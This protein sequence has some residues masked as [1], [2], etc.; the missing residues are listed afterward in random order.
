[1]KIHV[2]A[3][4]TAATDLAARMV[5]RRLRSAIRLRGSASIAVSGGSTPAAMLAELAAVKLPWRLVTVLQVDERVAPEGDPDRNANMLAALRPTGATIV[6]MPVTAA[7]LRRAARRYA[8]RLPDRLDLVHLGIGDD[9]H[10]ASWPPG[11]PV[12]RSPERVALCGEYRGRVRMTLT[13]G[14]VNAA[15]ARL[16]LVT[17]TAKAAPVAR[18]LA[19]D[20][21][22]PITL[23]HRANTHLVLDAQAASAL[24]AG[25]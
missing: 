12:V 9:G 13:P 10:T 22:L 19:G 17:G 6:P 15:R 3:D 25:R 24:P 21:A 11:D 16:V 23:V 8:D 7:D 14:T 5:E 1:V 2:T 18:W 4:A 20:R